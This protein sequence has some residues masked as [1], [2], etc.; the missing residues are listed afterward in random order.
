MQ[1]ISLVW[2]VTMNLW[3]KNSLEQAT[4]RKKEPISTW[5]MVQQIGRKSWRYKK[6]TATT[7]ARFLIRASARKRIFILGLQ[8]SSNLLSIILTHQKWHLLINYQMKEG[9][10]QCNTKKDLKIVSSPL[11]HRIVLVQRQEEGRVGS[12]W[13]T[14]K[15]LN[16][17]IQ[18]ESLW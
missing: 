7:K 12:R 2:W 3:T 8:I 6:R 18:E 9:S 4:V 14:T 1:G 16:E 11:F 15:E 5:T 17:K 10:D 13:T